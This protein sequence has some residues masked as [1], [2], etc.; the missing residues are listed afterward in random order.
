MHVRW[1]D[2]VLSESVQR[3]IATYLGLAR[4]VAA[5]ANATAGCVLFTTDAAAAAQVPA[6][7][8]ARGDPR[9]AYVAPGAAAAAASS[10]PGARR[11]RTRRSTCSSTSRS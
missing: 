2:K 6:A 4:E 7:A 9:A 3:P 5:R 10:R 1:G 8:C 11:A